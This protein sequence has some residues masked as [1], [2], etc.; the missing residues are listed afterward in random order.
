MRVI[1]FVCPRDDFAPTPELD[2]ETEAWVARFDAEGVRIVG[3]VLA[4]ESAGFAVGDGPSSP[5][6]A[7]AGFDVLECRD[8]D[9]A[10]E[11]VSV[12][13]MARLGSIV[14][15]PFLDL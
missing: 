6:A 3:D 8:L 11:V 10:R 13:P 5:S 9:H 15:R 7:I 14:V 12:H 2:D 4:P 1:M